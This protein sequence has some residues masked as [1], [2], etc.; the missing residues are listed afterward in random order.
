MCNRTRSFFILPIYLPLTNS[1]P[2]QLELDIQRNVFGSCLVGQT[3]QS[4]RSMSSRKGLRVPGVPFCAGL[5]G[6]Y[7]KEGVYL[8]H[9]FAFLGNP[10]GLDVSD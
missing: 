1:A 10:V 8:Q 3:Q 6:A 9:S 7:L 4:G 5:G 2:A